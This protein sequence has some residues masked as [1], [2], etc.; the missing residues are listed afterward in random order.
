MDLHRDAITVMRWLAGCPGRANEPYL[1][2][3]AT[4]KSAF[5]VKSAM[6]QATDT[7]KKSIARRSHVK[8]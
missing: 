5:R 2:I 4:I 7:V 8:A 3:Y 6:Y 1:L